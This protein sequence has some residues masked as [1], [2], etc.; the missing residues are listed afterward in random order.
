MKTPNLFIVGAPKCGTTSMS[1]WLSTHPRVYMSPVKEPQHFCFDFSYPEY[2]DPERYRALFDEATS[3]HSVVGEASAT[4]LLSRIAIPAIEKSIPDAKYI[5]MLRNPMEMAPSLHEQMVFDCIENETAFDCAWN[6]IPQRRLGKRI[7]AACREPTFL[8]YETACRL[9]EQLDRLLTFVPRDRVFPVVLDDLKKDPR[10][11]WINLLAFLEIDDDGRRIFQ[12]Q[13]E[14]KEARL[15][16]LRRAM[17]G[18]SSWRTNLGLPMPGFGFLSTITRWNTRIRTRPELKSSVR[19]EL[20]ASFS[21]D[22]LHLG[23]LLSRD[24]GHWLE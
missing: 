1:S 3:S 22:V 15:K 2:R 13:N 12:V 7:P 18:F 8:D 17:N 6:L 16:I 14:A 10:D 11:V 9:G 19:R 20:V 24:L 21:D 5:V 4:Y 23:D